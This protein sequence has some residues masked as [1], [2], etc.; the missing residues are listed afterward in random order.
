LEV[1]DLKVGK[2]KIIAI[3]VVFCSVALAGCRAT[4]VESSAK[5]GVEPF[6]KSPEGVALKGYD[7]VAYFT[8]GKAAEGLSEFEAEWMGAKWHFANARNRDLFTSEPD[9]YAPQYGKGEGAN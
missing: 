5:T 6:F 4:G 1:N 7:S 2:S 3:I 9:R 8:E